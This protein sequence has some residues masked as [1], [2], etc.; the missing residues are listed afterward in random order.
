MLA[1]KFTDFEIVV[2][3]D[4]STDGTREVVQRLAKT[5]TRIRYMYQEN[6]GA[7]DARNLG[8]SFA[9]G[10][11][12]TFLDSDDE[13][14]TEWLARFHEAFCQGSTAVV[15]CGIRHVD[16]SGTV[17]RR[18]LPGNVGTGLPILQGL[19]RSGTFALGKDVFDDISGYAPG[20]PAN[21]HSEL[22]CRLELTSR[23]RGW[24]AT[25]I[26]DVL[27]LAHEHDGPK[28][29]QNTVGVYQ[30]AKYVLERHGELLRETPGA[31]ASWCSACAGSAARL[32]YYREARRWWR[33]AI[34]SRPGN[35]RNYARCACACIPGIRSLVWRGEGASCLVGG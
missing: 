20:L 12:L 11:L 18:R 32:R 10:R 28:I 26:S 6:K 8:A 24:T 9:C 22:R 15:C 16:A 2:A 27:V 14:E 4:G 31:Y 35:L 34:V 21:Q 5:D 1:Q 25:C 13:V 19:Y 29:R 30:S 3:D 17:V 23:R 33:E 7:G